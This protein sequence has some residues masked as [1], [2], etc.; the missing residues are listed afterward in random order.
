MIQMEGSVLLLVLAS[1]DRGWQLGRR[2]TNAGRGLLKEAE[3]NSVA[4]S[5]KGGTTQAGSPQANPGLPD[6]NAQ[7]YP[8]EVVLHLLDQAAYFNVLAVPESGHS[9]SANSTGTLGFEIRSVLHRLESTAQTPVRD[10]GMKVAYEVGESFGTFCSRWAVISDDFVARP[11]LEPTQI[12]MDRSRSQR[13]AMQEGTFTFGDGADGFRGFGTGR[14][15]PVTVAGRSQLLAGAV[16][17]TLE[18]FGKFRGL[19]G[20]YVLNGVITPENGF[21]GN[22]ACR[23]LDPDRK[24]RTNG[25]I[26]SPMPIADPDPGVTYIVLRGQK[27]DERAKSEYDFAPDG[28]VRGLITPAQMRSAQYRCADR[29]DG[30]LRSRLTIGQIVGRLNATIFF[31]LLSPPGT[32]FVPAPFTTNELYTF[33][34]GRGQEIG[35]IRADAVEGESFGVR[36]A[37]APGQPA[38]RFAGYGPILSGTGAFTGMQG[39]LS[40]NSAIGISP[41]AL[42]L[43]H[44][45]R[46][47]D[48]D[49]RFRAALNA[50]RH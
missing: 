39:M 19:E 7:T 33:I 6:L 32:A 22:I 9:A 10:A 40:V 21:L 8:F 13:F 3:M 26:P 38:I 41:H 50:G 25:N 44:V 45:F 20:T 11:D 37:S 30:G 47:I 48:P 18:G 1:T 34:D 42:S 36:L 31:N 35:T 24:L 2:R 28:S 27:K 29:R 15:F 5:R 43:M 17:T 23:I 49:G 12:S 46:V 14:T 16:G 4:A